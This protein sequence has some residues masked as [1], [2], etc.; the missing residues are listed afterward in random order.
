MTGWMTLCICPRNKVKLNHKFGITRANHASHG[1]ACGLAPL[2]FR[3]DRSH[4]PGYSLSDSVVTD[5]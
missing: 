3:H 1:S 4:L 5:L 2:P